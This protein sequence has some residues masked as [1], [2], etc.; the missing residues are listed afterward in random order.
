MESPFF[1]ETGS[2]AR[3]LMYICLK[4]MMTCEREKM[5]NF[6]LLGTVGFMVRI[7]GLRSFFV[8]IMF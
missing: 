8:L 1:V 4:Q 3:F 2:N 5:N 6:M 7:Q